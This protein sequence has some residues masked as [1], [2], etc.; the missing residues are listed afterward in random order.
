MMASTPALKVVVA[1]D[2]AVIT[3]SGDCL[4]HDAPGQ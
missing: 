4:A 2:F 3:H 1:G